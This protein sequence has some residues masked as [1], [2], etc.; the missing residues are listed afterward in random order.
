MGL[1][2]ALWIFGFSICIE[3]V[4]YLLLPA[5]PIRARLLSYVDAMF[6][7]AGSTLM[8]FAH[9]SMLGVILV[10]I[11]IFKITNIAR[12]ATS[13]MNLHQLKSRF[14]R[15][16]LVLNVMLIA[17][18]SLLVIEPDIA[19]TSMLVSV[20]LVV[21]IVLSVTALVKIWWYRS[22]KSSSRSTNS[23]LPTVSVCI[24]ARNE[25]QD[26]P[27]CIESLLASSYPKLEILVLD[28]CS[29]DKTPAV[30]KEYAHKGVRF[31]SGEEPS[32]DWLAKNKAM[33]K[34]FDESTG[35]VVVFA[36]VDVRFS[37]ETINLLVQQLENGYKMVSILPKRSTKAEWSV[38]IQPLRYWWELVVPRWLGSRPPVLSTCWAIYRK[39][40]YKLGEFESYKR[41]VHPEAHFAKHLKDAY[42]F[43]LSGT[44]MG[45]TSVKL[46]NEQYDT[47]LRVRYPQTKSRPET[48][49]AVILLEIWIFAVPIYAVAMG[50]IY[51]DSFLLFTGL[52]SVSLLFLINTIISALVVSRIWLVGIVSLPF[53]VIEEWFVLI[54]SM[55]A[56]EFG[57]VIWK[58][59]NICLP[60]LKAEKEFPKMKSKK[61]I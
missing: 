58:E 48:V 17:I 10:L 8:L 25:T 38:F 40:L 56:Y 26:L 37:P 2:L 39:E 57:R 35:D 49:L 31:L 29:H 20:S 30:I 50:M 33:N 18:V 23:G 14:G 44:R 41:S 46:P 7:S 13:R 24:P 22:P 11:A 54:R 53:L 4:Q 47:A 32:D 19:Y 16:S 60:M 43:V 3:I 45:L 1:T 52:I 21:S 15:S 51:N 34:L 55:F 42:H 28:D 27:D 9:P 5:H 36:G 59:R 61:S 12:I 6:I